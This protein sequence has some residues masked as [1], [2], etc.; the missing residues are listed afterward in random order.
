MKLMKTLVITTKITVL[1]KLKIITFFTVLLS[2][3]ST[4]AQYAFNVGYGS[5]KTNA[6]YLGGDVKLNDSDY[7]AI[8]FGVGGY[9]T[10]LDQKTVVLPEIHFTATALLL[11]ANVSLTTKNISPNLGLNLGNAIEVKFGYSTSFDKK[12]LDDGFY[13]GINL[14]IGDKKFYYKLFNWQPL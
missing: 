1:K 11:M 13:F 3:N 9:V 6:L 12:L 8:N 4:Q 14:L 5:F 10:K 7:S 2:L